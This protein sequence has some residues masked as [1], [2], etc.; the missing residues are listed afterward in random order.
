M[1][2]NS[3]NLEAN[4]SNSCIFSYNAGVSGK[5]LD[6]IVN[7]DTTN[8]HHFYYPEDR[9]EATDRAAYDKLGEFGAIGISADGNFMVI[10]ARNEDDGNTDA[11]AQRV[12]AVVNWLECDA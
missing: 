3:S 6:C 9:V 2:V 10:G 4:V 12:C 7:H 1:W 11:G 8:Y 5:T